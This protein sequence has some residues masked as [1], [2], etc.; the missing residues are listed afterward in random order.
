MITIIGQKFNSSNLLKLDQQQAYKFVFCKFENTVL[1]NIKSHYVEFLGCFFDTVTLQNMKV[2]E[3]TFLACL[4]YEKDRLIKITN[5]TTNRV[6]AIYSNISLS[7]NGEL[8]QWQCGEQHLRSA[9]L[10]LLDLSHPNRADIL[11]Q[12]EDDNQGLMLISAISMMLDTE[13]DIRSKGLATLNKA[14][15]QGFDIAHSV[16]TNF[17]ISFLD[18]EHP[19]VRYQ[20]QDFVRDHHIDEQRVVEVF[21]EK[22]ENIFSSQE[23]EALIGI[24]LLLNIIN[25][26][27]LDTKTII[28]LVVSPHKFINHVKASSKELKLR[29]YELLDK[30]DDSRFND[31]VVAGLHDSDNEIKLAAINLLFLLTEPPVLKDYTHLFEDKK[32]DIRAEAFAAAKHNGDFNESVVQEYRKI[33]KSEVVL[34]KI[35]EL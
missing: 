9:F 3:I 29:F 17:L 12:L 11:S 34:Q 28:D 35:Q 21:K 22:L 6:Q 10:E 24:E 15:R 33:E 30:F 7:R 18:D 13:W 4:G 25:T 27:S 1:N 32:E 16:I 2:Q 23:G 19:L 14:G 20:A 5:S 8:E 31:V 26:R